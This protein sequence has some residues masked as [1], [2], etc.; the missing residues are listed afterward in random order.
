[1]MYF[2]SYWLY[3]LS[4]IF[5]FYINITLRTAAFMRI[6]IYNNHNRMAFDG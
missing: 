2:L 1:V 4:F 5:Y 3:V 6:K